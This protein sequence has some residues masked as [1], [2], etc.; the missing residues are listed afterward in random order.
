MSESKIT[1]EAFGS[2][3]FGYVG[4]VEPEYLIQGPERGMYRLYELKSGTPI[5]VEDFDDTEKAISK[6]EKMEASKC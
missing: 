4:S 5:K 1:W 6:A 2:M 3:L